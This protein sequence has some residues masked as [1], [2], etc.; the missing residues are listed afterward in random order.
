MMRATKWGNE[1]LKSRGHEFGRIYLRH[2][3]YAA[4][5]TRWIVVYGLLSSDFLE[6][7][8]NMTL[9]QGVHFGWPW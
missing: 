7:L 2:I 5:P 4:Q 8:V 1:M 3:S 9:Q 6:F